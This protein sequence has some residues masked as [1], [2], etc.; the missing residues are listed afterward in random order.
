L[1]TGADARFDEVP[2]LRDTTLMIPRVVPP[3]V[4]CLVVAAGR[5]ERAGGSVPKQYARLGGLSVLARSIAA[6]AQG[7]PDGPILV[8]WQPADAALFEEALASLPPGLRERVIPP[9]AGGSSRQASVLAGLEAL[10]A[11]AD[12]PDIVL[13]HDAARPFASADLV[14]RVVAAAAQ[15]GGAIPGL[16]VTDTIKAVDAA[17][18]V[19]A[20]PDRAT[21]RAV[22]TPQGF[23]L[24]A[25]LA[26]HRRATA[27][28]TPALTDDAAVMEWAGHAVAVVEG[29]P[30]NVK[31]T[32]PHDLRRA[33]EDLERKGRPRMETRVGSGFDVHAFTD[34]DHV[35]LGGVRI[36][37]DRALLGHSDADVVL[38]AVTDAVLGAL[39]DG[40]IGQHFPPS[41]MKW[42]GASSDRFLAFAIERLRARGGK[43][44]LIDVTVVCEAPRIGPHRDA[45]RARIGAICAIPPGRVAIKATTSEQLGFTGRREGIVAQALATVELPEEPDDAG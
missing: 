27:A 10:A 19:V 23:A 3:S 29:D 26:A 34:G 22:Q 18:T 40:D 33:A 9:V 11:L 43:L 32:T 2:D 35:T 28:G 4:A 21:L 30:A 13:V 16:A 41:D 1:A 36:A 17:G 8:V 38:H 5:G 15:G 45:M 20:T 39:A 25:L 7:V 14:R 6:L 24:P 44:R 37:H 12:P 31:L 42:K